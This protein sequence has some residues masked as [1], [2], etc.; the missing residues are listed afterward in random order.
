M[1]RRASRTFA[2]ALVALVAVLA[3]GCG[4]DDETGGAT[5]AETTETTPTEPLT[6]GLVPDAG[7]HNHHG[8]HHHAFKGVTPASRSSKRASMNRSD[9][10][11][12]R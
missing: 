10:R 2:L 3:A 4:G 7:Q 9:E 8:I 6:G 11:R 1:T 12:F 5:T